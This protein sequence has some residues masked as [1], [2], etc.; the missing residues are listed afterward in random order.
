MRLY[1]IFDITVMALAANDGSLYA[2]NRILQHRDET[3]VDRH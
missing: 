2:L 3:A 1:V